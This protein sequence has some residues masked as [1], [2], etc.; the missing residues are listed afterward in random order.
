MMSWILAF[1]HHMPWEEREIAR[2]TEEIGERYQ[3]L[4]LAGHKSQMMHFV[5]DDHFT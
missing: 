5:H 1:S 2:T 3:G 4:L